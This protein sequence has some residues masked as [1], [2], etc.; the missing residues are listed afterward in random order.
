MATGQ[1]L[2]KLGSNGK[3]I[4]SLFDIIKLFFTPIVFLALCLYAGTTGLW[5]YILSKTPI[6]QAYPIQAL[7]FPLV[8]IVS[9]FVFHEQISINKWIGVLIIVAGVTVATHR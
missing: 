7:A 4:N 6:S 5:L 9:S 1:M 3:Q 8:L 2:F